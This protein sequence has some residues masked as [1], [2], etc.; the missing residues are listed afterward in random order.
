[1][2]IFI[3]GMDISAG[4]H[5][6]TQRYIL[7][8]LCDMMTDRPVIIINRMDITA[9]IHP[10]FE[11]S[12]MAIGRSTMAYGPVIVIDRMDITAPAYPV[13]NDPRIIAIQRWKIELFPLHDL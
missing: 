4:F 9:G 7:G 2:S 11:T 3:D 13:G 12:D 1:M 10:G 5:P 8:I 6:R